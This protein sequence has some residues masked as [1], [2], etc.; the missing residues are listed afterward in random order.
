MEEPIG[1]FR[2]KGTT[3]WRTGGI[4]FSWRKFSLS[5]RLLGVSTLEGSV[6]SNCQSCEKS[7]F[8]EARYWGVAICFRPQMW[9]QVA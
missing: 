8:Y 6:S 4:I 3:V 9:V 1:V 2:C 5:E 7:Q